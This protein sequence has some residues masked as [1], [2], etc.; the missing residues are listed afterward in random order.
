MVWCRDRGSLC[1]DMV[2]GLQV[3]AMSQNSLSILRQC[4]CFSVVTMSRQRFPCHHRDGHDKRSGVVTFM[5]Q[6]IWSWQGILCRD[7]AFL[8]RDKVWSRPRDSMSRQ[9]IFMS[10]QGIFMSRQGLVK[11]ERF[12]VTTE[13][14][15]SRR[16][17]LKL[18]H[19]G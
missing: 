13:N 4:F 15:M 17:C 7:K 12:Y 9:G 8:C 11:A 19:D 14:L 18:C 3:V 1:C 5:L 2:L 16:S 10:R 6:W